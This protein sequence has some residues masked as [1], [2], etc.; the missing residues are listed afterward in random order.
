M[1][2]CLVMWS[3]NSCFKLH[4]KLHSEHFNVFTFECLNMWRFKPQFLLNFKPQ[5]GQLNCLDLLIRSKY[6][7][8]LTLLHFSSSFLEV[9]F[10][11]FVED[12]PFLTEQSSTVK[13]CKQGKKI[14]ILKYFVSY[15]IYVGLFIL[16]LVDSSTIYQI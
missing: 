11:D 16:W 6:V 14:Q 10:E 12:S 13:R 3:S 4:I 1:P 5:W 8:M 9:L 2:L 15:V 7:L